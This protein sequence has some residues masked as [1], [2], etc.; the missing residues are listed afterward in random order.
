M[1]IYY[2][3]T[4]A[5][6]VVA[7]L[8]GGASIARAQDTSSAARSDTMGYKPSQSRPDTAA[9]A[10]SGAAGVVDTVACKDGSNAG[11]MQ[12]CSSHGGID[13]AATKAALKARGIEVQGDSSAALSDTS[14][15]N[16][17]GAGNHQYNGPPSD[18]A[19]KAKP[20]TQTGADT[21]AMK[22]DTGANR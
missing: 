9:A 7:M 21:G 3:F 19:L 8:A 2:R 18:T 6:A 22:S 12:G 11:R 10:S 13:W 5:L 17:Q 1:H 16:K 14:R 20:G 4:T 15:V